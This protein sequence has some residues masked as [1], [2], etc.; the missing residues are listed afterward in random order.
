MVMMSL[1]LSPPLSPPPCT[2]A[3]RVELKVMMSLSLSPP[4]SPPPCTQANR[5][6]LYGDDAYAHNEANRVELKV[7][8]HMHNEEASTVARHNMIAVVIQLAREVSA[9]GIAG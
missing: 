6:E 5:V 2:Q 4:L 8:M 3:N 1:S 7:M 9:A